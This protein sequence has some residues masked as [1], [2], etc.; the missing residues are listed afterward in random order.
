MVEQHYPDLGFVKKEGVPT[1]QYVL[2]VDTYE[3]RE[4][5]IEKKSI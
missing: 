3:S 5:Y 4:C 1:A 2:D